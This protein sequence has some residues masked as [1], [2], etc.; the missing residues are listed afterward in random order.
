MDWAYTIEIEQLPQ[1][2]LIGIWVTVQQLADRVN[3]PVSFTLVRWMIDP[4]AI[5]EQSN[6]TDTATGSTSGTTE[7][8]VLR[9]VRRPR[10]REDSDV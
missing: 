2:G 10:A 6:S 7:A 4:E 9:E 5:L 1:T 3:R 8:Q